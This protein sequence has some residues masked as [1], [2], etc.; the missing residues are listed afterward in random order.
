MGWKGKK[1]PKITK[2]F[3]PCSVSSGTHS[4]LGWKGEKMAHNYI[5][6]IVCLTLYPQELYLIWLWFLVHICKMMISPAFFFFFHFFKILIFWGFRVGKR[7]ELVFKFIN[8]CQTEILRCAPPSHACDFLIFVGIFTLQK[9]EICMLFR[10]VLFLNYLKLSK[11]SPFYWY[12]MHA[13]TFWNM[14][15]RLQFV[16]P[17]MLLMIT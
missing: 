1:W 16:L 13:L 7:E 14:L 11:T 3:L 10:R 15:G 4:I 12:H 2:T 8:K 9:L 6:K 5:Q 17:F